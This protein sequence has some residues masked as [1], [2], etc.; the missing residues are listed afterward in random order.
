MDSTSSP[1]LARVL[2]VSGIGGCVWLD[3]L[4][5]RRGSWLALPFAIVASVAVLLATSAIARARRDA[6]LE[7]T[8]RREAA[9]WRATFPHG[10][11]AVQGSDTDS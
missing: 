8:R 11:R 7:R 9:F 1:W 5:F 6:E 2:G 3:S 10:V 4:L